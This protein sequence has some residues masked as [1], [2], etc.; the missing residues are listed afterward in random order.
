MARIPKPIG[1]IHGLS[2]KSPKLEPL[3]GIYI[4]CEGSI[5]EPEYIRAYYNDFC[6]KKKVVLFPVKVGEGVP[7]TLVEKCVKKFNE[8]KKSAKR[9]SYEKNTIWAVFDID[10]HN[11]IEEAIRIAKKI[12]IEVAISNPCFEV[13]GLMH[14]MVYDKP[15]T[16][17]EAQSLL[18]DVMPGYH[19]KRAPIFAW[20]WCRNKVEQAMQHSARALERREDEGSNF[21]SGNPSSDF[22][23][24]LQALNPEEK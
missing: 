1:N 15:L 8:L 6:T 21:P 10:E 11:D 14:K 12:G 24:L 20:S 19:H 7:K 9:D 2:R 23:R 3:H 16:R 22:H 18:A 13:Y 4:Y 5:T 17:F